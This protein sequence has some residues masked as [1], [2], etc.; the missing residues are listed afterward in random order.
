MRMRYEPMNVLMLPMPSEKFRLV[1][2]IL[3]D[4]DLA[5]EYDEA[6]EDER[7]KEDKAKG[8]G[9]KKPAPFRSSHLKYCEVD[10]DF[11]G[12]CSDLYAKA[13]EKAN[14]TVDALDLFILSDDDGCYSVAFLPS[15]H[16]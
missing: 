8:A 4:R 14:V 2:N 16:G 13:A 10:Y 3:T 6:K 15:P 11:Y 1:V 5:A 12:L 9:K 7:R